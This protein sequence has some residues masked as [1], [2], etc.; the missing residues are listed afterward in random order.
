[1]G[2]ALM[3]Q[4]GR[5]DTEEHRLR[6]VC[7]LCLSLNIGK[8]KKRGAY[9]CKSCK[10]IFATPA[11]KEMR[12]HRNMVPEHLKKIIEKKHKEAVTGDNP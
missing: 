4:H 11:M 12:T 1:V 6:K 3:A 2:C 5:I 8:N 7:P 9:R 10:A